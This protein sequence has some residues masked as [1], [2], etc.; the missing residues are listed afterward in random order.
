[1]VRAVGDQCQY[2]AQIKS[3]QH[4]GDPI[5]KP[6]GFM[7]NSS[8]IAAALSM[9]CTGQQGQCSRAKGGTH[10]LCSGKHARE[11]AK[12]PRDLCR[13]VLRGIRNQLK[14]DGLLIDG[15]YG[16]QAPSDDTEI[17]KHLRGPEQG[18]SGK[19]KDDLNGQILQDKLVKEARAKELAFFCS[20]NVWVKVPVGEA[21]SRSGRAPISARWV[22]VNKGDDMHPNYVSRLV[23]SK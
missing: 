5:K 2:G 10:R 11:A 18:F 7:T 20:K 22:D 16:I 14:K 17:L 6:T 8:E 21:R 23:A 4:S 12:Y 1:M 19:Y 15:C 3:G 13:A 9:R